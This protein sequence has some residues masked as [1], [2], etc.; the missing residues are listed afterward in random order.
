MALDDTIEP[1]NTTNRDD[2]MDMDDVRTD[3]TGLDD[4]NL[5]D[6]DDTI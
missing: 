4:E 5:F 1:D 6:E 2:D 3:T